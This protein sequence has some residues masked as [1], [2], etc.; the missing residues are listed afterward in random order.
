MKVYEIVCGNSIIE[1]VK[2]EEVAKAFCDK[3]NEAVK[4]DLR[5]KGDVISIMNGKS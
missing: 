3:M 5:I 1:M 4:L 2:T